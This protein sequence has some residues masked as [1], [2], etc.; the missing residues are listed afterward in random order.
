MNC[1]P[2]RRQQARGIWQSIVELYGDKSWAAGA[3]AKAKAALAE[4]KQ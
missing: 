3:V 1:G 2:V 4:T